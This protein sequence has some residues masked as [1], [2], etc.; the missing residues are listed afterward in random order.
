[1]STLRIINQC[2]L[3][4]AA[5]ALKE[6]KSEDVFAAVFLYFAPRLFCFNMKYIKD[7]GVARDISQDVLIRIWFKLDMFDP[8]KGSFSAWVYRISRNLC[9]DFLRKEE[10]NPVS[11]AL[12]IDDV[13]D[14]SDSLSFD[15]ILFTSSN[16]CGFLL[17]LPKEQS[18]VIEMFYLQQLT[19]KDIA[20]KLSLPL[21]T[22]KSRLRIG[23]KKLKSIIPN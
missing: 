22:V 7:P 21:G 17:F 4:K 11:K 16:I 15:N 14:I 13:L 23:L 3:E 12:L 9:I 18:V 19:Q 2:D 8:S 5:F 20:N 1:M 6:S 10:R